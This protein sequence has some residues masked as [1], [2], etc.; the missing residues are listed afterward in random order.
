MDSEARCDFEERRVW[1]GRGLEG[2]VFSS[3]ET[4]SCDEFESREESMSEPLDTMVERPG[5]VSRM[6]MTVMSGTDAECATVF[7]SVMV[8]LE[9]PE[10]CWVFSVSVRVMAVSRRFRRE[11]AE[12]GGRAWGVRDLARRCP[13]T[14]FPYELTGEMEGSSVVISR[15]S[16]CIICR[17]LTWR[18]RLNSTRLL[19]PLPLRL[20][21]DARSFP[22]MTLAFGGGCSIQRF[23]A[24]SGDGRLTTGGCSSFT[25][26]A[27]AE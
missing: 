2:S 21:V 11:L 14:R 13:E 4:T 18:P 9:S 15:S 6:R 8:S 26:G 22:D 17:V 20:R 27:R 5:R 23:S 19:A 7:P 1:M 16:L 3:L 10:E 12:D 24:G 25:G